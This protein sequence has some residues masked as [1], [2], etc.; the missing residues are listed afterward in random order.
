MIRADEILPALTIE[1]FKTLFV[2]CL[3][4]RSVI[5]EGH[6]KGQSKSRKIS[7]QDVVHVCKNGIFKKPPL[8]VK[9]RQNW[10]YE[11][12]G[13]DLDEVETT[14][15]VAVQNEGKFMLIVTCF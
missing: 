14:V 2:A 10:K 1:Q 5:F 15:V 4:T 8:Y 9:E 6:G 12:I 11:L 13:D 7:F 3:K